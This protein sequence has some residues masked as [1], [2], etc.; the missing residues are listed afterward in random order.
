MARPG[1][2]AHASSP[3]PFLALAAV[4]MLGL[5]AFANTL[6]NPF[7]WDDLELIRDR[8][9]L[10]D[11]GNLPRLLA[12][13]PSQ[14][15]FEV[16]GEF[17]YRPLVT[18]SYMI[19]WALWRGSPL[20][21]HVT[22][23]LLHLACS[24][25]LA[26][27]G[28]RLVSPP[29]GMLAGA[30]FAVHPIHTETVSLITGRVD[31]WPALGVLVAFTAFLRARDQARAWPWLAVGVAAYGLG[32]LGKEMALPLPALLLLWEWGEAKPPRLAG[33][34]RAWRW[35]APFL[36]VAAVY[37]VWRFGVLA[38]PGDTPPWFGG[39]RSTAGLSMVP[40]LV[41][42]VGLLLWPARLSL[43]HN[44]HVVHSPLDGRFLLAFLLLA[45]MTLGAWLVRRREPVIFGGWMGFLLLLGPVLNVV[46]LKNPMAERY[47]YLPS[48]AFCLVAGALLARFANWPALRGAGRVLVVGLLGCL[49]ARTAW[50]NRDYASES[51]IYARAARIG[52]RN[53]DARFNWGLMNQRRGNLDAADREFRAAL[54]INP[55][56]PWALAGMAEVLYVGTRYAEALTFSDQ[57]LEQLPDAW[58]VL[59]DRGLILDALDDAAGAIAAYAAAAERTPEALKVR[60]ALVR[61]Y[62]RAGR[63]AEARAVCARPMDAAADPNVALALHLACE[64]LSR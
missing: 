54:E 59:Y 28:S 23:A 17:Y 34:A 53:A 61:A 8:P 26:G 19:D 44:L 51:R 62:V 13:V 20:G 38:P 41:Q 30:L 47:L 12:A 5:L 14:R 31:L 32:L 60:L 15:Y 48:A 52:D 64:R 24:L 10:H 39:T 37:A 16:S 58:Q 27:I 9:F 4:A 40:V 45:G 29:A 55:R 56:H 25:L 1:A 50:R 22:N 3:L 18:A 35:H 57:A 36:A 43:Y 6:G 63:T 7:V 2:P 21:F 46:P 42:Y 49:L 11:M 33:L